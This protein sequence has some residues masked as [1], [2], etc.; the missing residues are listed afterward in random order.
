MISS[1]IFV[2][3]GGGGGGGGGEGGG[4]GGGDWG[5]GGGGI[6]SLSTLP[7]TRYN[8]IGGDIYL[9]SLGYDMGPRIE[10]GYNGLRLFVY[11]G[12]SL[13]TLYVVVDQN[14]KQRFSQNSP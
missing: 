3:E 1:D 5:G 13:C 9:L 6:L 2:V 7:V 4:G 11:A 14:L 12:Y 8:Q 10:L